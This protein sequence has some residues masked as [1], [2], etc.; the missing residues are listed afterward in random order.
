M[1]IE[2]L[3]NKLQIFS[4]K[5][6][7]WI[8]QQTGLDVFRFAQLQLSSEPF[9]SKRKRVTEFGDQESNYCLAYR[10]WRIIF[11]ADHKNQSISILDIC[12]GYTEADLEQRTE[13][14]YNDKD[15]HR[16]YNLNVQ[17]FAF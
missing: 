13:D 2:F 14:K 5:K 10:T 16:A 3:H 17:E 7:D 6:K 1:M 11:Q 8:Y 4:K 12:S 15:I 9:N